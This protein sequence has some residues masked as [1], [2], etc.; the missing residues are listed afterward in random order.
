MNAIPSSFAGHG[1]RL[2][3]ADLAAAVAAPLLALWFRDP[4]WHTEAP[5]LFA[6]YVVLALGFSLVFLLHF[7][8]GQILPRFQS[9]RD[10]RQIVKCAAAA[11]AFTAVA[12]FSVSRLEFIPR[13]LPLL[14]FLMMFCLLAGWRA[15]AAAIERKGQA[16]ARTGVAGRRSAMLVV[17]VNATTSLYIRL[18]K[19]TTGPRPDI[20]GLFDDDPRLHGSSVEGH[21]ILGGLERCEAVIAELAS[22]GVYVDR[23]MIAHMDTQAQAAARLGL[24]SL[25]AVQGIELDVLAERLCLGVMVAP[26]GDEADPAADA[27]GDAS[28]R[29]Y[30]RV[31]RHFDVALAGLALLVLSPVLAAVALA[32][33]LRLGS[34]VA[35]WQQRVGL[36]GQPIVVHKFRTFAPAVDGDGRLLS[37]SERASGLGRFLRATRLDELPQLIDVVAGRMSLIGPRPLL[38]ADLPSQ[39]ALRASVL[40]GLTGWAQVHGGK[41]VDADEKNALDEWYVQHA[42]PATDLRI[43]WLTLRI[44]LAGDVREDGAIEEA[45]KFRRRRLAR[46]ARAQELK[47]QELQAQSSMAEENRALQALGERLRRVEDARIVPFSQAASSAERGASPGGQRARAAGMRA[48]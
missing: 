14:H 40:P 24:E 12:A 6:P 9:G 43:L 25:C 15:A 39:Y 31:R 34:P 8:I 17:G 38:P 46:E 3:A 28:A 45:L 4:D 32:I 42:S 35:F 37:E 2:R 21:L 26:S 36:G 7:R 47:T 5:L 44:V 19:S 10:L 29:R 22:H 30:L 33:R 27:A 20:V 23:I 16:R 48:P 13:S 41:A 1:R 11:A 18:L